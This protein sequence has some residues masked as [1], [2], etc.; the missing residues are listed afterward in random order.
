M[1]KRIGIL[2][3]GGD[4]PGQNVCL[5][6]IVYRAIEH[7]YQVLGFRK[8]WEGLLNYNPN[9]PQS[10]GQNILGLTRVRT[11]DIDRMPGAYLHSSRIDPAS[12]PATALPPFLDAQGAPTVDVTPH[13]QA[14]IEELGLEALIVLGDSQALA[15]AAHLAA[16]GVPVIGVPKSVH[17]DINGTDYTLGF[18]T[19]LERGVRFIHEMRAMAASREEIAVVEVVGRTTGLTTLLI[20]HLAGADR[21]LIPEVPFDPQRLA[22]CLLDDKRN[23]PSNYAILAVAQASRVLP[24]QMRT[25]LPELTRLANSRTLAE[26]IAVGERERIEN[27]ILEDIASIGNRGQHVTGS[28]AVVT[29]ILENITGQRMLFQPLS[30]LIRSG[31]PDGQDLLGA[32]NFAALTLKLVLGH[33]YGRVVCYRRQEN[34]VDMPL[35]VVTQHAGNIDVADYYD[36][37]TFTARP[38]IIWAARV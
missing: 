9:D 18:S 11:R 13:I 30:Y 25:Y 19:A 2:T 14:M 21:I 31:E 4:A 38:D 5:K 34:Y 10:Y 16:A 3:G 15:Y 24:E 37:E 26:A 35:D 22:A 28:G 7:G 33:Q 36:A 32:M 1:E 17:N 8:G 12:T 6:A 27:E 20:A 29:E 23:N